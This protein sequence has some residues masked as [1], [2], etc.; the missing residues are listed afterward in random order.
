MT[1]ATQDLE[2]QQG[3]TFSRILRWETTPL[4]YKA[5]TAITKASPVAITAVAHNLPDGWRAAVV[6]A[7][8]M[9][10]INA[11]TVPPRSTDFHQATVT[12]ADTL[13]FNEVSSAAYTTYTSGGSLVYYTPVTLAA[14]TARMHIRRAV[15]SATSLLALTT[16]NGRITIDDTAKTI[17]LLIA[18]TDTDDL[19]FTTAVYDLEM[20]SSGGVVT[21]LLKGD[22]TLVTE[23]T[24]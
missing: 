20:V 14:Y 24:R 4:I 16:E 1:C 21:Q 11:K 15:E 8:G 23:V 13:T 22:V 10:Q 19:S 3:K 17:T 18:A 12:G 2:I 6:A 9:R 7:G 5:I